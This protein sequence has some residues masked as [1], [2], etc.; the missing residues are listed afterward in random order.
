[1]ATN[2]AIPGEQRARFERDAAVRAQRGLPRVPMDTA[3][4]AA[5]AH[6]LPACA[7]VAVGVGP[8]IDGNVGDIAHRRTIGIRVREGLI[9]KL[10][11]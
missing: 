6:G 11:A 5:M 4:L 1:M 7:G 10:N 3:L 9:F 8:I 2:S